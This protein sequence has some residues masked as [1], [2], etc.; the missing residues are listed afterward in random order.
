MLVFMSCD[1]SNDND[2]EPNSDITSK[3]WQVAKIKLENASTYVL[4]EE[5]YKFAFT[6]DGSFSFNLDVN[7][8]FGSYEIK[9]NGFS[10]EQSIACT[11]ACCD[12]EFAE[13]MTHLLNE[14]VTYIIV[15]EELR[16]ET[17]NRGVIIFN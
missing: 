11:E 5:D 15:N 14:S 2:S 8:C 7:N 3:I 17:E 1:R 4:P 9:G 10:V 12:S 6:K 16:I 13:D